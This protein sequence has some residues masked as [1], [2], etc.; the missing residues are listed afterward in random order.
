MCYCNFLKKKKKM[1][2]SSRPR[3]P[4][5]LLVVGLPVALLVNIMAGV[6]ILVIYLFEFDVVCG[7]R[8]CSET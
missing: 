8:I 1:G 5:A 4:V 2:S 6:V 3:L 7:L